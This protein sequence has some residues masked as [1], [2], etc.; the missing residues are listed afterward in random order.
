VWYKD[1][2]LRGMGDGPGVRAALAAAVFAA[3]LLAA[4]AVADTLHP[5]GT[6]LKYPAAAA[7][8]DPSR[9]QDYS[10]LYLGLARIVV[11]AGGVRGLR[12]VQAVLFAGTA[13]L[14]ALAV[15]LAAGP[16][17]GM[18]A[19][20]FLASYRPFLVYAGVLEPETLIL[21]L[22]AAAL[23][24]GQAARRANSRNTASRAS[25]LWA[26]A[27]AGAVAMAALA[28][29]QFVILVPVWIAWTAGGAGG[30]DRRSILAAT[31]A[32]VLVLAAFAGPRLARTGNL[33]VMD[34]GTVFYE[35]NG[36]RAVWGMY[37][38]PG[39]VER[40]QAASRE[41]DAAHVVYRRLAEAE[42][43]RP[44]TRT[45]ANRYWAGLAVDAIVHRP[46]RAA[47]RFLHKAILAV[48]PAEL[49]D[50]VNALDFDRRVRRRLPW[51]WG[52][53][54]LAAAAL[55]PGIA[56]RR[57]ELAGPL[58]IAALA[59]AV[60]VVFYPSARQ[61]L[62]LALALVVA[63]AAAL[64]V[65]AGGRRRPAAAAVGL[66]LLVIVTWVSAPPAVYQEA[67][68][69]SGLAPLPPGAGG[70]AAAF[71]DGR[72]WRPR[73]GRTAR[74][75]VAAGDAFRGG[76]FLGSSDPLVVALLGAAAGPAWLR[77]R[78]DCWLAR[79]ALVDGDRG[80]A[81]RLA[82]DAARLDPGL[83]DAAAAVRA[84]VDGACPG[85]ALAAKPPPGVDA[86]D[87]RFAVAEWSLLAHGPGC[88][89]RVA[90]PLLAAFPGVRF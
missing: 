55:G 82:G 37:T 5:P 50:L 87:F 70:R 31:A 88:A 13:V 8:P 73:G 7:H 24:A 81:A 51:G 60:Q 44:L 43:G 22:L 14:A 72:S 21:F 27:A 46:G 11:P 30:R 66:L 2:M 77:A 20:L 40:L 61:R 28:R 68:L 45:R 23:A 35:G 17:A 67:R 26:A 83:V 79:A 69:G 85:P 58:S 71:L 89:R 9:V 56:K 64:P 1:G 12:V 32:A 76:R 15:A 36:P 48:A 16:A 49:H 65:H 41:P 62:P 29:P 34:P 54:F 78:A 53:V 3:A 52:V 63:A 25:P 19:G 86:L 39:L 6:F 42:L 18:A 80:R 47:V 84:L 75:V 74:L 38:P 4:L 90:G 59:W 10:P 33:A 57:R